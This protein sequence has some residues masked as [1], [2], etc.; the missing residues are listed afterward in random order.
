MRVTIVG[1]GRMGRALAT[2]LLSGGNSVTLIGRDPDTAERLAADLQEAPATG[3]AEVDVASSTEEA[4]ADAEVVIL[5]TAFGDSVAFA[6]DHGPRLA[7]KVVVDV[8]N[9]L[10]NSYDGLVTDNGPSAA[11]SIAAELPAGS[12]LVKAFNT[13]FPGTLIHGEV[14]GQVLDVFIAGDDHGATRVVSEL[15]M[16]GG[17]R[18]IVVGGLARARQLEGL[19]FLG[20]AMQPLL[21]SGFMSGWKLLL[22]GA[23]AYEPKRGFPR[24][25]VIGVFEETAAVGAAVG[26]L[27]EDGIPESS[28]P[29]MFGAEGRQRIEA[30]W[31]VRDFLHDFQ[32]L[33]YEQAHVERHLRELEAGNALVLVDAETEEIA[34]RIGRTMADHGGRFVNYYSRWVARNLVP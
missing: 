32:A 6:R 26:E 24:N 2:R 11:E 13:V 4:L 5:A 17:M 22:P 16:S 27:I 34:G 18:P 20:I 10:N 21:G 12:R 1:P 30:A 3:A 33:G 7:A 19:G 28:S 31:D 29:S 9:P 25:A 15:A 14:A 8:C 23:A